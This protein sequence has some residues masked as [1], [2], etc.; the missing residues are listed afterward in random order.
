MVDSGKGSLVNP[1]GIDRS[2]EVCRSEEPVTSQVLVE[3]DAHL[4]HDHADPLASRAI[5]AR[6]EGGKLL[7]CRKGDRT[8]PGP[9]R[10]AFVS[11]FMLRETC[12]VSF[13]YVYRNAEVELCCDR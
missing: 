7:S 6:A 10:G 4:D 11:G 5:A 9:W 3:A 13:W 8:G 12:L 1:G 2:R